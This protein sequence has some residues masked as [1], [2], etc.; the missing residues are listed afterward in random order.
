M[1]CECV[2]DCLNEFMSDFNNRGAICI[3]CQNGE[4]RRKHEME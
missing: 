1:K 2:C 3:W 4:H